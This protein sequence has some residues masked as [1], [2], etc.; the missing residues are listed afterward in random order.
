MCK[1]NADNTIT[2][3]GTQKISMKDFAIDPPTF[4]LGTIKTG[5]DITLS[6]TI[7]LR[8]S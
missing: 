6:F 3:T 5:N 1:P 2:V 7:V 8:R 4:M